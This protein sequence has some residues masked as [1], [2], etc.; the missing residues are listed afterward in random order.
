MNA[1]SR[2][3]WSPQKALGV[4]SPLDQSPLKSSPKMEI[5]SNERPESN[6]PNKD[7]VEISKDPESPRKISDIS[8]A[9]LKVMDETTLAEGG[10]ERRPEVSSCTISA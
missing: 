2:A 7:A 8:R 9:K 6:E 10:E 4:R 5:P 3:A 1:S